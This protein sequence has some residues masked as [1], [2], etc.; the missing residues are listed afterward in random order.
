MKTRKFINVLPKIQNLPQGPVVIFQVVE[1]RIIQHITMV[2]NQG[3]LT[4][5]L[6]GQ[7]DLKVGDGMDPYSIKEARD[8]LENYYQEHGWDRP[9]V[10]ILEGNKPGDT[11]ATFLID[12]GRARRVWWTSFVGNTI[13]SSA[14][15]R[16]Q[17]DTKPPILWIFKGDLNQKRLDEDVQKLTA[18][19]RGLGFFQAKIGREITF[20]AKQNWATITFVI[21]EGPRYKIRNV[22]IIGNE[23]IGTEV[24][25]KDLK[26]TAGAWF[27]QGA[28]SHDVNLVRD[29]YGGRGYVFADIEPDPRL[30]EQGEMDL[31]YSVKE[32]SRYRVGKINVN[33]LGDSTHTNS[34]TIYNRLSV[35]PATSSTRASCGPTSG[36]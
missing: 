16:T 17:I 30:L 7:T 21:N 6:I 32:G 3:V 35:R 10:T 20:D 34:R 26:L 28:M 33:I 12:E 15:L 36:G 18:Y 31:I 29:L 14:R 2:G 27:N 23:K 11:G 9:R 19:Y 4:S 8:K 1:R 24:I 22:S 25:T 13:A 5:S